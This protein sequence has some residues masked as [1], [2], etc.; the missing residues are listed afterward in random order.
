MTQNKHPKVVHD[1][2]EALKWL[3][4][5][6]DKFPRVRRYTLG[7]RMETKLLEVLEQCV[8]AAYASG[9][10][11][12]VAL[13]QAS[14]RLNVLKHLWRLAYELKVIAPKTH[15]HGS[16]LLVE[17]GEQIGGWQRYLASR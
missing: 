4:P 14:T 15:T 7:E 11:K 1:C 3:I 2:H 6:L 8:E 13:K 17:L 16:K 10:Q 12:I 9:N 5:Q